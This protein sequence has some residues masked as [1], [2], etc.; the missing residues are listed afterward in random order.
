MQHLPRESPPGAQF[1]L[2]V[3]TALLDATDA[4]W[5]TGHTERLVCQIEAAAGPSR[6]KRE[7][8]P[9]GG[10]GGCGRGQPKDGSTQTGLYATGGPHVTSW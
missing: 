5:D 7:A 1:E 6:R 3:A 2:A 8:G 9:G 10:G 4:A